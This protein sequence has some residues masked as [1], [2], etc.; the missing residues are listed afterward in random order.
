M[1]RSTPRGEVEG[2]G[3]AGCLGTHPGGKLRGLTGVPR[4]APDGGGWGV[5]CYGYCCGRYASYWNPSL[6]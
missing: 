3:Q 5:C 6:F 2:S 4:P 1:S